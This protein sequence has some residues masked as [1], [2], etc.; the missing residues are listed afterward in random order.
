MRSADL[1]L[2]PVRL[3]IIQAFLGDRAL[4]TTQLAAEID[5]IPA[6]SL[7]RHVALLARADV[8]QVVA[9][10]RVRG[11]MERTYTM[12]LA[13][14]QLSPAE[15]NKMSPD[16]H[17]HAFMAFVAGL[18][19]DFDRYLNS[20]TP[21]LARDMAGYRLAALWL[22]D[23]ELTEFLRDLGTI[24]QPRLANAP[25]KGR[26]RRVVA[27]VL[28]PTPDQTPPRHPTSSSVAGDTGPK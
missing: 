25:H 5:D 12:R 20:G 16:Q 21:D 14:A 22:S 9:E 8:I 18:L 17:R 15:V 28:L 24:V 3:R 7:Y 27:G 13:A 2:H 1:L 11:A 10:R 4:T 23:D 6:G 19:G 26:S